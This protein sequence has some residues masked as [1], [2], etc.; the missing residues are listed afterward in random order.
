[1]SIPSEG[2]RSQGSDV[3]SKNTS[4]VLAMARP[5][6]PTFASRGFYSNKENNAML[7]FNETGDDRCCK[8]HGRR[9]KQRQYQPSRSPS[10][11]EWGYFVDTPD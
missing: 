11:C 8:A 7:F 1:M 6:N 4:T 5:A 3:S 2:I 10:P 9:R